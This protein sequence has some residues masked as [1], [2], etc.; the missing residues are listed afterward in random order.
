[1]RWTFGWVISNS[2]VDTGLREGRWLEMGSEWG[3]NFSR[4]SILNQRNYGL[5]A[6][7]ITGRTEK[8]RAVAAA[9]GNTANNSEQTEAV[10]P[11][12]CYFLAPTSKPVFASTVGTPSS[13]LP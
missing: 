10:Q 3:R 6:C 5:K 9:E 11:S 2:A 7:R 4:H 1:M 8:T 13:V 12:E